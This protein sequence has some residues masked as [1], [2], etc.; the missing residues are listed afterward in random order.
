MAAVDPRGGPSWVRRLPIFRGIADRKR[1]KE[2]L[3][4]RTHDLGERVKELNC[5]YGIS[6]LVEKPGMSL[7]EIAQGTAD[8]IPPSWQYPQVTCAR[9]S[10]D[11]QE[12]RTDNFRESPWSQTADIT[13]HGKRVGAVE[14]CCLEERL[15]SDEGPFLKEERS[16][17]DAIAQRLG[18]TVE[19]KRAEEELR[20]SEQRYRDMVENLHDLIVEIDTMLR[21][22]YISPRVTEMGYDV[23]EVVGKNL[24]EF[25]HPDDQSALKISFPKG[26]SGETQSSWVPAPSDFRLRSA[27]GEMRWF[28]GSGRPIFERDRIVGFRGVMTDVTESRRAEEELRESEERYRDTVENLLSDFVVELDTTLRITYISPR[29]AEIT[30]YDLS[31][32]L[33]K[34]VAEFVH[35]D[36]RSALITSLPMSLSGE[37]QPSGEPRPS[38]TPEPREYRFRM[39]SGEM[40]WFCT[41]GRPLFEGDRVVGF[42]GVMT[43]VTERRQ[44]EEEIRTINAE[45]EQRVIARTAELQA[46]N[47]ELEEFSYS[48]SHDLRA[49][50]RAVD[51]FSRR[52]LERFG[53]QLDERAS[54]S[55]MRVRSATK[56]MGQ[57]I[58]DLLVLSRVT[59]GEITHRRVDL[60]R[61][62]RT[63]AKELR[64]EDSERTAEF[65]IADGLV[66]KCDARLLRV[67]IE[68]LVGN[69]WKFTSKHE[70]ARID[71]GATRPED[72][73]LAYFVR[74]DGA[75][76]DMAYAEKLFR[77]FERLHS[78]EEFPG[79]GVGLASVQHIIRRH[80]G[81]IW[82]EAEVEGGATFY[83]TL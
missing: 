62:A 6:R 20:E 37:T 52:L 54:D 36:D 24:V 45:L 74:D 3:R 11:G 1:A 38:W 19:S 47:K 49:P 27:S 76:F 14:V 80:G 81:R 78:V 8:L 23:S 83:F 41:S 56:R 46:A 77:P 5:L 26:L 29:I 28:R 51:G 64:N 69:A 25:V 34:K 70:T 67:V 30:G 60:S 4:Q 10:L 65:V 12:F 7:E 9:I 71:F 50:L 75:G 79:N 68:N 63:T 48:V 35:P 13:V 39:K 32:I 58:D 72:G 16:L 33:G 42:R 21:I 17:I 53:E 43:D 61:L 31:E 82:A 44:A 18:E 57:L 22:T 2:A 66:A 15:E 73:K 40:R 59:R 55:L